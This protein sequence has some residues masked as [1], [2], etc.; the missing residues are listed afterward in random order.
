[1]F[2]VA[3]PPMIRSSSVGA[4]WPAAD[5]TMPP[6]WG[7]RRFCLDAGTINMR[8]Y[9]A[10]RL[11][12]GG[13]NDPSRHRSCQVAAARSCTGLPP[14]LPQAPVMRAGEVCHMVPQPPTPAAPDLSLPGPSGSAGMPFLNRRPTPAA[15]TGSSCPPISAF[16]LPAFQPFASS[17]GGSKGLSGHP[18]RRIIPL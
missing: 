3:V 6:R 11:A 8:S 16:S 15:V 18:R 10:G 5:L 2:I 1:M 14:A 12:P 4:A 7:L 13:P 9:G 17:P